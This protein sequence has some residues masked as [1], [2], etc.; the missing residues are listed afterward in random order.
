MKTLVLLTTIMNQTLTQISNGASRF[1][2]AASGM[3]THGSHYNKT[4]VDGDTSRAMI[5]HPVDDDDDDDEE[6]DLKVGDDC[7]AGN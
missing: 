4:G 1:L 2:E 3:D 5:V 7:E 6:A